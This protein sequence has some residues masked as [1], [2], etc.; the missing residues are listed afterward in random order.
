MNP[1][2]P[3]QNPTQPTTPPTGDQPVSPA[4]GV[5]SPGEPVSEPAQSAVEE[6]CMTCGN[7]ASGGNCVACGQGQVSCTCPSAQPP[8]GEQSGPTQPVA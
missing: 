8:G 5:A 2:D 4:S 1:D 3:N 7:T 6:K